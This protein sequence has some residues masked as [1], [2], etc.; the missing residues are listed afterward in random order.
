MTP[1]KKKA[2]AMIDYHE[3]CWYCHEPTM[4]PDDTLGRGWMSCTGCGATHHPNPT[5]ARSSNLFTEKITEGY[6][7][8]KYRPRQ[9]SLP[10]TGARA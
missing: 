3:D 9:K 8:T 4:F 1:V 10:K 2:K 5:P 6:R 7:E